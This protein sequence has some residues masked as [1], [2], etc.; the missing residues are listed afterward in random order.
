MSTQNPSGSS[1]RIDIPSQ[2]QSEA[3]RQTQFDEES[4]RYSTIVPRA[5][6]R[7][8]DPFLQKASRRRWSGWVILAL[9]VL[10]C[11]PLCAMLGV[12]IHA[13]AGP[14]TLAGRILYGVMACLIWG[15]PLSALVTM[16]RT[17]F[18]QRG[19]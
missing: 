1:S 7:E 12:S 11:L 6:I 13:L 18:G 4:H 14:G 2:E 8:Q 3:Q 16:T 10:M 15:I 9:W 17:W 19:R 5:G